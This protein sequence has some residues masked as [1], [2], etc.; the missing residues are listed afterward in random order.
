LPQAAAVE[1]ALVNGGKFGVL[2]NKAVVYFPLSS[3][4]FADISHEIRENN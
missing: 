2:Q 3:G 4:N 1:F